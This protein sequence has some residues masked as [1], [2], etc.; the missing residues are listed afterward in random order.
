M[1]SYICVRRSQHEGFAYD[2]HIVDPSDQE[3]IVGGGKLGGT[4]DECVRGILA[5]T[6]SDDTISI[7]SFGHNGRKV[8]IPKLRVSKEEFRTLEQGLSHLR[9]NFTF[10][11]EPPKRRWFCR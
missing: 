11:Y 7:Q 8:I 10:A 9:P 4:V 3:P 6:H 5:R 2:F 1:D